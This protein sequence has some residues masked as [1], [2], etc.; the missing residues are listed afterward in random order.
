MFFRQLKAMKDLSSIKVDGAQ[1]ADCGFQTISTNCKLLVEI[2]LSKC[3][4]LTD[5]GIIELVYGC[6]NLKIIDLTC[7]C[8]ITDAAISA[9]ANSCRNLLC[10]KLESCNLI[11]EKSL[12]QLGSC[13]LLLEELDLT[14]CSGV[15]DRGGVFSGIII[16]YMFILSLSELC[17]QSIFLFGTFLQHHLFCSLSIFLV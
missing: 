16:I 17:L 8:F 1:V 9:V 2:G 3:M 12:H 15:D 10:L 4:G 7:C 5:L 13:C 11:T 14:D 6:P